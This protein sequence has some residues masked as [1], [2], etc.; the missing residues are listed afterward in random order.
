MRKHLTVSHLLR[1]SKL[2]FRCLFGNLIKWNHTANSKPP[3]NNQRFSWW[4]YILL[5][6]AKHKQCTKAMCTIENVRTMWGVLFGGWHQ[7]QAATL[8]AVSRY[9][10]L[11]LKNQINWLWI[12][13]KFFTLVNT[14]FEY[15][16]A[17]EA[18]LTNREEACK[19][20]HCI[21]S[22]EF[23]PL[24]R[25]DIF[26]AVYA[27]HLLE[28]WNGHIAKWQIVNYVKP[29]S[30][31]GHIS[32]NKVNSCMEIV[33]LRYLFWCG[34]CRMNDDQLL[35]LHEYILILKFDD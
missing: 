31:A 23:F 9:S 29:S 10:R 1:A 3:P 7:Y 14:I 16:D 32:Q 15:T 33:C 28:H 18:R 13:I 12:T 22:D 35:N 27:L 8:T 5:V 19:C 4:F 20:L 26:Y 17:M 21:P 2:K 34:R 11:Q 30:T 24:L 6:A 25:C